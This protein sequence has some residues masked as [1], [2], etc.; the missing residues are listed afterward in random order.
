MEAGDSNAEAGPSRPR[1]SRQAPQKYDSSQ[2]AAQHRRARGTRS[3]SVSTRLAKLNDEY[4]KETDYLAGYTYDHVG[5]VMKEKNPSVWVDVPVLPDIRVSLA[6][7]C[8]R[9]SH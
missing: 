9:L 2:H 3:A 8:M 7:N 1:R 6:K 4:T 5:Q